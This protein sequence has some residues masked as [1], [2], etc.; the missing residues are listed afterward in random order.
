MTKNLLSLLLFCC[1]VFATFG[2]EQ[3]LEESMD[4]HTMFFGRVNKWIRK[5]ASSIKKSSNKTFKKIKSKAGKRIT[6]IKRNLKGKLNSTKLYFSYLKKF[7]NVKTVMFQG[8]KKKC[9]RIVN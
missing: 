8:E 1:L 5:K 4:T 2:V 9:F 3:T 7:K 6:V